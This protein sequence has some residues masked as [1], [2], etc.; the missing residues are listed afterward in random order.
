MTSEINGDGEPT[1][2]T[3]MPHFELI[4]PCVRMKLSELPIVLRNSGF[5]GGA[6][7]DEFYI[8]IERA[9]EITPAVKEF[10]VKANL[11]RFEPRTADGD[12]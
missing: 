12:E 8:A 3:V 5:H 11:E 10:L 4:T 2:I 9:Q 1:N 7:R 6:E